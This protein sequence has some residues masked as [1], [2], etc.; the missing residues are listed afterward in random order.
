[1]KLSDTPWESGVQTCPLQPA[2]LDDWNIPTEG[3]A[4]ACEYCRIRSD[5]ISIKDGFMWVHVTTKSMSI[6]NGFNSLE[7][8]E[9]AARE[10]AQAFGAIYVRFDPQ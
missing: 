1:V 3:W 10:R 7:A 9:T 8:A 5:G 4:Y 2:Q 6:R